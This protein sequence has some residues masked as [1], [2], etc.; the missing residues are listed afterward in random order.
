MLQLT[1]YLPEELEDLVTGLYSLLSDCVPNGE[2]EP[3]GEEARRLGCVQSTYKGK[4]VVFPGGWSGVVRFPPDE[5]FSAELNNS[6]ISTR[7]K[8]IEFAVLPREMGGGRIDLVSMYLECLSDP[9]VAPHMGEP[10][11]YIWHDQPPI[12]CPES[13]QQDALVLLVLSYLQELHQLCLRHLRNQFV[14]TTEN[15]SGRVK[16]R[17]DIARQVRINL[18]RGRLDRTV[19]DFTIH[20]NNC[21]ENQILKTAL[22]R[23]ARLLTR[24]NQSN[25]PIWSKIHFCRHELSDVEEVKVSCWMVLTW[26]CISKIFINARMTFRLSKHGKRGM[27]SGPRIKLIMK[28]LSERDCGI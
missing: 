2:Q 20:S 7:T 24:F 9:I 21:R 16:G 26:R 11:V 25:L 1:E 5:A 18:P 27:M 12:E 3:D 15:L 28:M 8:A 19:C 6:A 23:S 14:S 17:I 4:P 10:A 22:E 13:F